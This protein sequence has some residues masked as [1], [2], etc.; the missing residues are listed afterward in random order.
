VPAG[1]LAP[2]ELDSV[3]DTSRAGDVLYRTVGESDAYWLLSG[4]ERRQLAVAQ[5]E[6]PVPVALRS[7]NDIL[8]ETDTYTVGAER[9]VLSSTGDRISGRCV[10]PQTTSSA[11]DDDG[12]AITRA[13]ATGPWPLLGAAVW[14]A[15]A[16]AK[17]RATS[18]IR[19]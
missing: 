19:R 7:A 5:N 17:R 6:R 13:P 14:S 9:A 4:D 12:C 15:L 11:H 10:A 18:R 2:G 1:V 16:F 8:F 3:V